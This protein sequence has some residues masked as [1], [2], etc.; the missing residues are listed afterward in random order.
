MWKS[1][2]AETKKRVILKIIHSVRLSLFISVLFVLANPKP[3]QTP[4]AKVT[5]LCDVDTRSELSCVP[6][7]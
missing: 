5:R 1:A 3:N 6:Q 2:T 4:F 7:P